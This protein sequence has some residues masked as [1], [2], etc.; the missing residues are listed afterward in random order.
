QDSNF[1]GREFD[2]VVMWGLMFLLDAPTQLQLIAKAAGALRQGGQMLFTAPQK[3]C[4]WR[5]GMT[6]Q[7]SI[8]LGEQAYVRALEQAGME[9]LRTSVDEGE[10]YYYFSRKL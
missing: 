2:A 6:D 5:D 1:F 4:Q 10:N 8:S 7:M 3:A 9:L